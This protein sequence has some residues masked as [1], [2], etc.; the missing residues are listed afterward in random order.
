MKT[1]VI[2]PV[3]FL[4]LSGCDRVAYYPDKPL[5]KGQTRMIGHRGGGNFDDGNTLEA[6]IHGLTLVD[7][8]EVDLQKSSD[9]TLWLSHSTF[10]HNCAGFGEKC[11]PVTSDQT[12]IE[13]DT[14]LGPT[15]NYT[16]LET[17]FK[18]MSEN[19]PTK[20]ISLDVKV[21][22]PCDLGNANIT[23]QMNQ[24]AQT[25]IDLTSK[26]HLENQVMV[27]S[28]AGDFL[29][30]FLK[31]SSGIETY[32]ATLGDFELGISR[33]LADGFSGISFQFK[34]VEPIN[35][36]LVDLM[37]RKGLKIQLWL[38]NEPADIEEAKSIGADFIQ[39]DSF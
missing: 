7:G 37:H 4:L 11:F 19:F 28:E 2:L 29:Y 15:I 8:I 35:K 3:L 24:M 31:H 9:N 14:C 34:T 36:D 23:R 17:V 13:I 16:R 25:I 1:A 12:I 21:W 32:L 39:T 26:Y 18:Y 20:F 22:E 10:T 30:Y 5:P 33:A 27:E 6:C 38:V